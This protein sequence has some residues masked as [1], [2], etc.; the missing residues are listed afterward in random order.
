MKKP[1]RIRNPGFRCAVAG[2]FLTLFMIPVLPHESTLP[3][4]EEMVG[5]WSDLRTA[6]ADEERAWKRQERQWNEEIAQLEQEKARLD[7]EMQRSRTNVRNQE[8][9]HVQALRD[10][11]R[12]HQ[13][14]QGLSALLEQAEA[15]LTTWQ[16]RLP[17]GM[18]APLKSTFQRL[19]TNKTSRATMSNETR[20]QTVLGLYAELDK[21]QHTWHVLKEVLSLPDGSRKEM[22]TLYIGLARAFAVSPHNASAL[23]GVPGP[24]GWVWRE[25]LELAPAIRSTVDILRGERP[26]EL[27]DLPLQITGEGP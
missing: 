3:R 17:P 12:F 6:I 11:D 13:M 15:D 16:A 25:R 22:D 7:E 21:L 5:E 18:S 23:V 26:A 14:A 9:K 4:L 24:T 8:E 27:V 10:R 19:P 20:L 1:L 2:L